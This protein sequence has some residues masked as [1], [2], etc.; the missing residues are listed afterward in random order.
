[1]RHSE[2]TRKEQPV[3]EENLRLPWNPREGNYCRKEQSAMS[4]SDDREVTIEN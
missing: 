4:N 2:V 1:M 3:S